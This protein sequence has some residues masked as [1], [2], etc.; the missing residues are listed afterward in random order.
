MVQFA[1]ALQ[2]PWCIHTLVQ[3]PNDG[4]P[5]VGQAKVNHVPLNTPPAI[6]SPDVF[7]G[8]RC[9]GCIG[10]LGKSVRE[11]V[12]VALGLLDAPL[13]SRITP[14]R[15]QVAFSGWRQAIFSHARP[16]SFA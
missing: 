7:T 6:A 3:N 10:Q 4:N 8:R 1:C 16:A 13:S 12:D 11:S 15:L 14:D 5:V 2:V 9:L